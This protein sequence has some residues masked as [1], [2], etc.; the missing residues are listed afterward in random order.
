MKDDSLLSHHS[1]PHKD[2]L[3][4]LLLLFVLLTGCAYSPQ[5]AS[6][7]L[8]ELVIAIDRDTGVPPGEIFMKPI[9]GGLLGRAEDV[10]I[11]RAGWNQGQMDVPLDT[12]VARLRPHAVPV[13]SDDSNPGELVEPRDLGVVR[14]ATFFRAE[15]AMAGCNNFRTGLRAAWPAQAVLVY[16]DG[17]GSLRGTRYSEP[18]IMEYDLEF[19]EAGLY[20]LGVRSQGIHVT[21]Q[22]TD[23]ESLVARVRRADC[24][25]T[26]PVQ[27]LSELEAR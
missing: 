20:A 3:P 17:P 7:P 8:D 18:F 15:M 6:R 9:R 21:Q 19:P 27:Q 13:R 23:I 12:L 24:A 4:W 10:E 1:S 2:V 22:V 14:V 5:N 16:V 25:D 11:F 26:M